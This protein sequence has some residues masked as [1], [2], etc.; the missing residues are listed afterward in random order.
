M[1]NRQTR[2]IPYQTM[3]ELM[4]ESPLIA[5]L[6]A[7]LR[8]GANPILPAAPALDRREAATSA[9]IAVT[10]PLPIVR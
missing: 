2:P 8:Q 5:Q 9:S 6:P 1:T 10:A 7:H 3:A 4:A